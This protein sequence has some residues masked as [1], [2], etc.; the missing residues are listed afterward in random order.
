MSP[1]AGMSGI[2]AAH[3]A[4]VWI[5]HWGCISKEQ[6][7]RMLVRHGCVTIF[8]IFESISFAREV[9]RAL[10]ALV[11]VNI[12]IWPATIDNFY[13]VARS[14][15]WTFGAFVAEVHFVSVL[16]A[17]HNTFAVAHSSSWAIFAF[18]RSEFVDH[19]I[20]TRTTR[21]LIAVTDGI[22]RTK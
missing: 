4:G 12:H 13:A 15:S 22:G 20:S 8:S 10:S 9:C 11:L 2:D 3:K 7:G 16:L 19:E 6:Y 1:F 5:H 21:G 18:T 17:C 14:S